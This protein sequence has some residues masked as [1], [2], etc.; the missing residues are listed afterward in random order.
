M[1]LRISGPSLFEFRDRKALFGCSE[2]IRETRRITSIIRIGQARDD[3]IIFGVS[4]KENDLEL[5]RSS[6]FLGRI[7]HNGLNQKRRTVPSDNIFQ[8]LANRK[9]QIGTE[10]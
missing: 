3:I 9:K 10:L 6:V 7:T 5:I 4:F 1:C 8:A 2:P